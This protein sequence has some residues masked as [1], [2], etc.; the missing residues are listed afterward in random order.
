MGVFDGILDAIPGIRRFWWRRKWTALSVPAEE[1]A[2]LDGMTEDLNDLL[3]NVRSLEKLIMDA[4]LLRAGHGMNVRS[5]WSDLAGK[6]RSVE[7]VL[8]GTA[9]TEKLMEGYHRE[10][11]ARRREMMDIAVRMSNWAAKNAVVTAYEDRPT[12]RMRAGAFVRGVVHLGAIACDLYAAAQDRTA[13]EFLRY[14]LLDR[15]NRTKRLRIGQSAERVRLEKP[16]PKEQT[17]EA[18]PETRKKSGDESRRKIAA[19]LPETFGEFNID[20]RFVSFTEAHAVTRYKLRLEKGQKLSKAESV[21]EEIA[22][23][24]GVENVSISKSPN[25][26]QM[27]YIDVPNKNI[28]PLYFKDIPRESGKF[29]VGVGIDGKPVFSDMDALC[30][31]LIAG[32]TGSGK[33]T[34]L[35]SVICSLMRNPPTENQFVMIDPK[36]GVELAPYN[37]IPHMARSVVTDAKNASDA[38]EEAAAE[39]DNRYQIFEESGVRKL[40]EY[41]AGSETPLPRLIVV[42][43]ELA[44]LMMTSGKEVE[45]SISRIAQL[46]RAA[47][48]H[49]IIATQ[50]PTVKVITGLIKSNIPSRVAFKAASNL[51]SRIILDESGAEKLAGKGDMLFHPFNGHTERLQGAYIETEEI[52]QIIEEAKGEYS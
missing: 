17:A 45:A 19:V 18:K 25:E 13:E 34:F 29:F 49:L 36:K 47:G 7:I 12:L 28:K 3:K 16:E 35:N 21:S 15:E 2:E 26:S 41:N 9:A 37:G 31:L 42:I 14:A 52:N 50:R 23:R 6:E 22:L 30:H 32:T 43:D 1:W 24:L 11:D 4:S 44:D 39:M 38:L 40:S 8:D 5:V 20:A 48:V 10:M 33:S 27:I 51:E 46:G